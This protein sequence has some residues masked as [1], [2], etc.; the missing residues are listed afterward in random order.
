M[1]TV[2]EVLAERQA[3]LV[4][5]YGG[6]IERNATRQELLRVIADAQR[7]LRALDVRD[8]LQQLGSGVTNAERKAAAMRAATAAQK[9]RDMKRLRCAEVLR[10][11]PS[12]TP[13]PSTKR[14]RRG[15]SPRQAVK[16][17]I[18]GTHRSE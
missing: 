13:T 17:A 9:A 8:Q 7:T 2:E 4:A 6:R 14:M 16:E 18:W 5:A 1:K 12:R 11:L 3:L 10:R 15:L